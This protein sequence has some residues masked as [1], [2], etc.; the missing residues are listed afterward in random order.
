METI[1][2]EF[3]SKKNLSLLKN[4]HQQKR[5]EKLQKLTKA[6]LTAAQAKST[7]KFNPMRECRP[8]NIC[9][10]A[11]TTLWRGHA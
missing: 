5:K 8:N 2:K 1:I 3:V 11:S 9:L 4:T 6:V 10:L 7:P